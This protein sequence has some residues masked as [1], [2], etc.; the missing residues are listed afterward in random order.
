MFY[1]SF[2]GFGGEEKGK[3]ER[4]K[5]CRFEAE[6]SV[7]K[8]RKKGEKGVPKRSLKW[9]KSVKRVEKRGCENEAKKKERKKV[10]TKIHGVRRVADL[11]RKRDPLMLSFLP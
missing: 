9:A 10:R 2:E 8:K 4:K 1:S 7:E 5:R 6:K 3:K 11:V